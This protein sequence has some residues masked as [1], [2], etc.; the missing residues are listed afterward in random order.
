MREKIPELHISDRQLPPRMIPLSHHSVPEDWDFRFW[1]SWLEGTWGLWT[2]DFISPPSCLW[3]NVEI[4]GIPSAIAMCKLPE[5]QNLKQ[6]RIITYC[7][8]IP[9]VSVTPYA[10]LG[11]T[12]PSTAQIILDIGAVGVTWVKKRLTWWYAYDEQ[13]QPSTK[14]TLD[15]WVAGE[16]QQIASWDKPPLQGDVNGI[17]IGGKKVIDNYIGFDDTSIYIPST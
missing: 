7:R 5:T 17:A 15:N 13:N 16:W 11:I 1:D 4:P 6:G 9:E 12:A 14:V 2:V 3:M 10:V 8:S